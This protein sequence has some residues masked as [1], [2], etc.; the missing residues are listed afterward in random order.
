MA[1]L[2][3]DCP[4]CLGKSLGFVAVGS[5]LH[6]VRQGWWNIFFQCPSCSGPIC[7][8]AEWVHSINPKD[9]PGNL[10]SREAASFLRAIKVFSEVGILEIPEH[11]PGNVARAFEE[12]ASARKTSLH[13][14]AC[15]G[16]RRT[17]ELALKAFAPEIEAWTLEK[18]IDKLA[19]ENKITPALQEWAH[20]LRLDG[21]EA[22]HGDG[23]AD[24]ALCDQMHELTRFL[25]TYLYTMPKQVELARQQEH[26]GGAK[27][28]T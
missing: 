20:Q 15:A 1:V 27:A 21:N 22:I 17:M 23:E 14:V 10:R 4:H 9:F 7:A 18:R 19:S 12:S 5:S 6:Q 26:D 2:L 13:S 24:E 25:L 28:A 8:I 3:H 11:L 16:Y